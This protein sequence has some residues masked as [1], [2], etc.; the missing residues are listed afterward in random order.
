[1]FYAELVA[2]FLLFG[3][4]PLRQVGLASVVLLQVLIAA[5]GNYGFFNLL[6]VVLCLSL[7]DDRDWE[8]VGRWAGR[9]RSARRSEV[10]RS[11]EVA[12]GTEADQGEDRPSMHHASRTTHHAPRPWSWPRRIAVGALGGILVAVTAAITLETAAPALEGALPVPVIIP[13]PIEILGQWLAP[14]RS[15]N[16]YGLF[17]VMT[18][19]RPEITIEGSDDG[20]IWKPYRFRWKPGELDRAPRFTTPHLPRLDWQM[21]FA[22]LAGDCRRTP[23]FLRF[24][25]RLLRGTPEVLALLR[26]SPFPDHPPRYIRARLDLYTFTRWGSS[27]WWA[28]EEVGLF[29]PPMESRVRAV[30]ELPAETGPPPEVTP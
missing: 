14:L 2:P 19:E 3:P 17:A 5:T 10:T 13:A 22:A 29:C 4:R 8:A 21:W 26:E 15:T 23:W 9:I 18:T 25:E 11:G 24:E 6:S 7:L 30:D 28:R 12:R 27:D 1:M 20:M 16:R